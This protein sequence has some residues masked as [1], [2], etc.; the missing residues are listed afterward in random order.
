MFYFL[1]F[2]LTLICVYSKKKERKK[3]PRLK[4][5]LVKKEVTLGL[6]SKETL[7]IYT[8]TKKV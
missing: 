8:P 3:P 2:W 1:Y 5:H 7:A 6:A 4:M